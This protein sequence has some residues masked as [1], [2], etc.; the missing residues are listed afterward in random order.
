MS[1]AF[2]KRAGIRRL[3]AA[4]CAVLLALPF[5]LSL[6]ADSDSQASS[7]VLITV[8]SVYGNYRYS[9][10]IVFYSM[11]FTYHLHSIARNEET[12][13]V[14]VNSG[15]WQMDGNEMCSVTLSVINHSDTPVRVTAAVDDGDFVRCG[16]SAERNGL[17][18]EY[19]PACRLVPGAETLVSEGEMT[20]TLA[21]YPEL[22][23]YLGAKT[24]YV[25]VF[26]T[27]AGGTATNGNDYSP[28]F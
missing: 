25:A 15:E 20:L 22:H 16:V 2:G 12:G 26:V 13:E 28:A 7:D 8:D 14:Y 19:L 11:E 18:G 6:N 4:A 23:S 24:F 9:F 17:S 5:G 21:G 1:C 10:D 3:I 27:P